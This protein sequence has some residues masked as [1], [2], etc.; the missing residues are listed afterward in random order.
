MQGG[1][2]KLKKNVFVLIILFL[3]SYAILDII[4]SIILGLAFETF[5]VSFKKSISLISVMILF[6]RLCF[7]LIYIFI[8]NKF[9]F[10]KKDND[11][12]YPAPGRKILHFFTGLALGTFLIFTVTGLR[13]MFGL[14]DTF[15]LL[16]INKNLLLI[17]GYILIMLFQVL[18]E[19][20]VFRRTIF[21][22]LRNSGQKFWKS[23]AITSLIFSLLHVFDGNKGLLDVVFLFSFSI[24]LCMFIENL[25]NIWIAI[26]FHL[27]WNYFSSGNY[28]FQLHYAENTDLQIVSIKAVSIILILLA[29]FL[30]TKV[31]AKN[32]NIFNYRGESNGK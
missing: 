29:A 15:R 12:V 3:I 26:G 31:F 21:I 32:Q 27:G 23:A 9:I 6:L 17:L 25:R 10:R 14:V 13:Y 20:F 30:C 22:A 28:L 16:N 19:E 1:L 8:F 4:F 18:L 24:L 7:F 5:N 11:L 2:V